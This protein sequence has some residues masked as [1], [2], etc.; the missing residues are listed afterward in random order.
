MN[1]VGDFIMPALPPL[2]VVTGIESQALPCSR[3]R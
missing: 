3:T 2:R 1:S